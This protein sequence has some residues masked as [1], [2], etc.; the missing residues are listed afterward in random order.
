MNR[1]W[2]WVD[3]PDEIRIEAE[4]DP[5][6]FNPPAWL[7]VIL[8]NTQETEKEKQTMVPRKNVQNDMYSQLLQREYIEY[9]RMF[10]ETE[11]G[12]I[13]MPEVTKIIHSGPVTVVFWKDGT[14]TLVRCAAHDAYDEYNA[15]C[16]ALAIKMYG[17]NSKLKK[18]I[19]KATA[20][21]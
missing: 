21:K 14:K 18:M 10:K 1:S 8:N 15:F 2:R 3:L 7:Q 11:G 13:V 4:V 19:K 16:A 20:E 12:I 5:M 17:N 6:M 9:S